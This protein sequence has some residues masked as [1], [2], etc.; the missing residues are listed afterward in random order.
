MI[1][2]NVEKA[3]EES[4]EVESGG[5]ITDYWLVFINVFSIMCVCGKLNVS[6]MH[7]GCLI[8]FFSRR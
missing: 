6:V 5:S 7:V 8:K 2:C 3:V 1:G 4:E